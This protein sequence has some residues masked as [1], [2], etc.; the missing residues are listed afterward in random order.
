MPLA[1]SALERLWLKKAGCRRSEQEPKVSGFPGKNSTG[2][3]F[4]RQN[5]YNT[6][7]KR[8]ID[9]ETGENPVQCRCCN[10]RV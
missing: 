9:R 3:D 2:I 6:Q 5:R 8:I 4:C 7:E 10:R 1:E